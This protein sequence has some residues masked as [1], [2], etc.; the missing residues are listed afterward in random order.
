LM[1]SEKIE[2]ARQLSRLGVDICEAGFPAAS[3]GDF[4]SVQRVARE[5][6][7]LTEGRASG[8]PMTIVGL[9]RSVPADIQRA[10]DAVKDAPKHRIHVF[11]ATSDIH[12]EYKLRI[13]REECVKRAVAAVTFAK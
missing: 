10:Y 1:V 2:I 12:L 11:L 5:V 9:A 6:G 4:E 7:P 3:V 8:E 13:S